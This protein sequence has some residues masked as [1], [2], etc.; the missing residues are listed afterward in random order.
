MD[1]SASIPREAE[2]TVCEEG[3]QFKTYE[4][5]REEGGNKIQKRVVDIEAKKAKRKE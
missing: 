4:A 5:V 2:D 3:G 1:L